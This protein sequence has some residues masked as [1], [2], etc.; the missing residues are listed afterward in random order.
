VELKIRPRLLRGRVRQVHGPAA[1]DYEPDELIVTTVVRNGAAYAEPFVDH[2]RRLGVKHLVFLDNGST[3]DTV[4]TLSK[5]P[6][7]TVLTTS[8]PYATFE[9]AM[10]TYLVERFSRGRWNLTV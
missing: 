6:G 4:A 10:K 3:D 5:Y 2:Y 7:T 9:N 1:I 8:A